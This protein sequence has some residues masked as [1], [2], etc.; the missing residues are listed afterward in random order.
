M[1]FLWIAA[2]LCFLRA[3]CRE[4][5]EDSNFSVFRVQQFIEWPRPL[6]WNAF[7][8]EVQTKPLIH[9]MPPP[10]HWKK[11]FSFSLKRA[12]SHPLPNWLVLACATLSL[13]LWSRKLEKATW[14]LGEIPG[15]FPKAWPIFEQPCSLSDNAHAV[16]GVKISWK[17][18]PARTFKQPQPSWV[19]EWQ[20]ACPA[21]KNFQNQ[22]WGKTATLECLF[23]TKCGFNWT[24]WGVW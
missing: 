19:S 23:M 6:H 20:S 12:L 11:T 18:L 14:G 3:D 13:G 16:A 10:S 9:W 2:R 15:A 7:P 8:V 4:G 17:T 24:F 21:S 1:V 5:D 22:W